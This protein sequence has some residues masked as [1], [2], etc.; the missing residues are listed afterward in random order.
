M[1]VDGPRLRLQA[2]KVLQNTIR[3]HLL[4]Y[5]SRTDLLAVV[6]DDEVV[7]VYR[8]G[9]QRAFSIK[10]KSPSVS[11]VGLQW[12]RNGVFIQPSC[13]IHFTALQRN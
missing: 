6:S 1:V 2:E 12:V 13:I 9:G 7:E 4:A 10:R 11:V 5:C 8:I 3:P